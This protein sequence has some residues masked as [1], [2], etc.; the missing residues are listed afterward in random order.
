MTEAVSG[1]RF[2]IP[3]LIIPTVNTQKQDRK[4]HNAA[5][6]H[7][8]IYF[9]YLVVWGWQIEET[10]NS[11]DRLMLVWIQKT[12]PVN[13]YNWTPKHFFRG[14]FRTENIKCCCHVYCSE[15]VFVLMLRWRQHSND[16]LCK[17]LPAVEFY[18]WQSAAWKWGCLQFHD[19]QL[20]W[21]NNCSGSTL[22]WR[23]KTH[24]L[25]V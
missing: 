25:E 24:L 23:F 9:M 15:I 14:E 20:N 17:C 8:F 18:I 10:D 21:K 22:K 4:M 5:Q 2:L 12:R 16:L 11:A 6:I 13:S 1:F 3:P 19:H 7:L